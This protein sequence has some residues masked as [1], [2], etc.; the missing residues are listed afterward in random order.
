LDVNPSDFRAP[1]RAVALAQDEQAKSSLSLAPAPQYNR[2]GGS[3]LKRDRFA[4]AAALAFAAGCHAAPPAGDRP[5]ARPPES[6]PTSEAT[7]A[8]EAVAKGK[9]A[10][11]AHDSKAEM[12]WYR[13]AAEQGDAEGQC[14]LARDLYGLA[15]TTGFMAT[16]E[17][18]NDLLAEKTAEEREA[19]GWAR[20]SAAQGYPP[21]EELMGDIYGGNYGVDR[22]DAAAR[23]WYE[24]AAQHGDAQAQFELAHCYESGRGVAADATEATRWYE[25]AAAQGHVDAKQALWR[26]KS[27]AAARAAPQPGDEELAKGRA[28]EDENEARRWYRAAADKGNAAAQYELGISFLN[29]GVAAEFY[30]AMNVPNYPSQSKKNR[31][32]RQGLAWIRKSAEQGYADAQF[33]LAQNLAAGENVDKDVAQARGWYEKAA[34]QGHAKAQEALA[35]M[36]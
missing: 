10:G 8:R 14:L 30:S 11:D 4:L 15:A 9:A 28:T 33:E 18:R 35:K 20:K 24:K 32:I 13:V 12:R 31:D 17:N 2:P 34:V 5:T 19:L 25:K 26:M 21:G 36:R 6:R 16:T 22:D 3:I 1:S 27:A 7:G 29:Y 23:S